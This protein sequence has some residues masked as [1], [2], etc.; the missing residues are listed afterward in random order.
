VEEEGLAG[1]WVEVVK[2]MVRGRLREGTLGDINEGE[3]T[4]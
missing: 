4:G 3:G 1:D 2:G